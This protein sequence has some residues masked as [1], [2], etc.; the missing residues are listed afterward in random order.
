[1]AI[2]KGGSLGSTSGK[3][4]NKVYRVMNGKNFVSFRPDKY[5]ISQ[6]K[7]AVSHRAKFSI[8][9]EFAKY[10]N[11]IPTLKQ[12]WKAPRIKGTT[13]FNRIVMYNSKYVCDKSPT[14]N[15]II[16][17]SSSIVTKN[18]VQFPFKEFHFSKEACIIKIFMMN[19]SSS[20][21]YNQDYTLTFVLLFVEPKR[22]KDKYFT[23]DHFE[24][25]YSITKDLS[26]INIELNEEVSGNLNKYKKIIIYFS[27]SRKVD[28]RLKYIWSSSYSKDFPLE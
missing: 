1:M 18:I 12:I 14:V 23:L 13:S 19:S 3:L 11:S 26:E 7:A 27:A 25:S 8:M 6:S 22:K 2:L 17:P 16:T 5:N 4:G 9:I 20:F 21:E 28:G 15:N 10:V 24:E